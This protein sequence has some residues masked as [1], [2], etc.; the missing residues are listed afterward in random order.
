MSDLN[1]TAE[2]VESRVITQQSIPVRVVLRNAASSPRLVPDP[3]GET[4]FIYHIAGIEPDLPRVDVSTKTM[5]EALAGGTPAPVEPGPDFNLGAG[6]RSQRIDDVL[7]LFNRPLPPGSYEITPR[8]ERNG[9]IL[10]AAPVRVQ[11]EVPRP[12]SVSTAISRRDR[13]RIMALVQPSGPGKHMLMVQ[14]LQPGI[15]DLARIEPVLTREGPA[16]S[17]A[18][19]VETQEVGSLRWFAWLS[20]STLRARLYPSLQPQPVEPELMVD[21]RESRLLSPGFTTA[22]GAGIFVVLENESG[23][24]GLSVYRFHEDGS[25]LLWRVKEWL[26]RPPDNILL[27]HLDYGNQGGALQLI[28]A[29]RQ[30]ETRI[31]TQTFLLERG[32]VAVPAS[33]LWRSKAPIQA[34][35][36]PPIGTKQGA[37]LSI[38][39]GPG[40]GDAFMLTRV[41]VP[42]ARS[43]AA[44][45][46]VRLPLLLEP[47]VNWAVLGL[48]TGAAAAA[49]DGKVLLVALPGQTRWVERGNVRGAEH[50]RLTSVD[51]S[52]VW[53]E[54]LDPEFGF[55]LT[56]AG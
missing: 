41:R 17:A 38:V 45:E 13:K 42:A 22:D 50:L 48:K 46:E 20:G 12:A 40:P 33:E 52:T 47:A 25:R 5:Y 4:P 3:R 34:W 30:N 15:R 51:G 8:W 39:A 31:S 54:W 16:G 2:P 9:E 1:M 32:K 27:R 28:W 24:A 29:E 49:W 6:Y 10:N 36:I 44:P 11:V 19:S 7:Q 21:A 56:R 35:E 55:R 53:V 37:Q 43:G 26:S 23:R 14:A 18:A